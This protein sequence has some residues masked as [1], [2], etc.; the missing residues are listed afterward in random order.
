MARNPPS[1]SPGWLPLSNPLPLLDSLTTAPAWPACFS[2][3]CVPPAPAAPMPAAP[4]AADASESQASVGPSVD[5]PTAALIE[6]AVRT[7]L[8]TA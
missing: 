8:R 5:E 1:L 4:A 7:T 3:E 6:S 2:Q